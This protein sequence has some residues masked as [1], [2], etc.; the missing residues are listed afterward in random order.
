MALRQ[1]NNIAFKLNYQG[2]R[3]PV[4]FGGRLREGAWTGQMPDGSTFYMDDDERRHLEAT[5]RDRAGFRRLY[6]GFR[7][8][9]IAIPAAAAVAPAMAGFYSGGGGAASLP[10][11]A[12]EGMLPMSTAAGP[13]GAATSAG[14]LAT[15]GKLFNS[16][17]FELATNAGL[18]LVGM[19]AQNKANA[20]ARADALAGQREALALERQR[21]EL[22]TN[23]ANLDREE[24]R[25]LNDAINELRKRELDA[26]E[27]ERA[28]SRGLVEAREAR[29]TPY[30]DA[31]AAALNR[32]RSMW[33]LA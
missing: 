23:N 18:S 3:H 1:D 24:A 15:M 30:R 21:L 16:P 7:A 12:T 4:Y 13:A 29:L 22:E 26:A 25:R 2:P 32:L 11:A 8:A 27:E 9:S 19:H 28:F 31:S 33:G 6:N 20:Q 5:Q 14:R 10:A 17:G